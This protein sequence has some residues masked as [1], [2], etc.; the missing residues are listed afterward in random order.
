[1]P[2]LWDEPFGLVAIE[3][4]LARVPVVAADV[5]GIG[6]GLHDEEHALLFGRGD[7]DAAASS[8]ERVLGDESGTAERVRRALVRAREFAIAPYLDGQQEFV[9]AAHDALAGPRR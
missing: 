7:A 3:G 2:S 1:M 8:L 9:Q 6:E 4:A 5:G